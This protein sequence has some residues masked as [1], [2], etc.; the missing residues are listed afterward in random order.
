VLEYVV[1]G[2]DGSQQCQGTYD[3]QYT[4]LNTRFLDAGT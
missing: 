4:R 1:R 2:P 3:A